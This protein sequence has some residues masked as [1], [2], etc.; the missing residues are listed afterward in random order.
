MKIIDSLN[1]DIMKL[2][3]VII[4]LLLI[5]LFLTILS[6]A[7]NK[8]IKAFQNQSGIID[9]ILNAIKPGKSLEDSLMELLVISTW[10]IKAPSF[11]F[12][13]YDEKNSTYVLKAATSMMGGNSRINPS[14]SGLLPHKKESYNMPATV[15]ETLHLDLLR[16]SKASTKFYPGKDEN[17]RKTEVR[18]IDSTESEF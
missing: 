8:K 9:E 15:V 11:A 18:V 2:L 7:K 10:L 14:Y 16:K 4:F 3:V 5:I 12:Y 6:L 17:L 1:S 13:I